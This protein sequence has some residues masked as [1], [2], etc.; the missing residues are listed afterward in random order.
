MSHKRTLFSL[1]FLA[2][3][4]FLIHFFIVGKAVYGDGRFYYS[5]LPSLIINH[6]LDL[7]KAYNNIGASSFLT[8]LGY[9]ANIYPIGPPIL[10]AIPFLTA[11]LI[12][13]PFNLNNGYNIFYQVLIGI[14]NISLVFIGLYF[15][16]KILIDFFSKNVSLLV[17]LAIFLSTNLLFY[18]SIDVLN[19]HSASFFLSSLFLYFWLKDKTFKSSIILGIILG[20]LAMV[21]PQDILFII[22][23]LSA[24]L[25]LKKSYIFNFLIISATSLIV[26]FPQMLMWKLMW[27]SWHINP[28]LKVET[29]N[30]LSSNI[31]G[32]LFN[33]G[34]GLFLWT[35]IIILCLIGIFLFSFKNKKIG[36]PV[37][38]FFF[39]QLYTISSWSIW[40]QGASYSGRMFISS[41]PGLSLGLAYLLSIKPFTRIKIFIVLF[42]ST[43]NIFLI[44]LFLLNN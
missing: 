36:I 4:L 7:T 40:W 31:L 11:H 2:L 26:F 42:F 17:V 35:P 25:I 1:Y 34:S 19:S 28:Y 43:L 3:L 37:T 5:Y 27:G 41:L 12:L 20:F 24:L 22:F 15:L 8:P 16:Y 32:V 33:K 10:W 9:T 30:L 39:F 14:F 6:T 38:L 23:P 21:R 29:F 44:L 13:F 18:G